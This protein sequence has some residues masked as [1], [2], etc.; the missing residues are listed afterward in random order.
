MEFVQPWVVCPTTLK[1]IFFLV[2]RA[3]PFALI[4]TVPIASWEH[5]LCR[6]KLTHLWSHTEYTDL[7]LK[8][9]PESVLGTVSRYH[10]CFLMVC[11]F[12][13]Q[14]AL[15]NLTIKSDGEKYELHR[16][17]LSHLMQDLVKRFF[18]LAYD[19]HCG[20]GWP[21]P[22][23]HACLSSKNEGLKVWPPLLPLQF[24][25]SHWLV[26]GFLFVCLFF[27]VVVFSYSRSIVS[28][29]ILSELAAHLSPVH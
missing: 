24:S 5:D 25:P 26:F 13:V 15:S 28:M 3:L 1:H 7:K 9:S 11:L 23:E 19:M 12:P 14:A 8:L 27:G 21:H 17:G 16:H 4:T 6:R 10:S 22:Q 2:P 29:K 20:P 18:W